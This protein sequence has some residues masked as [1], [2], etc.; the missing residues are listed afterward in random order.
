[1]DCSPPGSSVQGI[2][3]ARILE[4]AVIPFSR[5]SFF[6]PVIKPGSPA[7][8]ADSLPFEPPR[9]APQ[10]KESA[11]KAIRVTVTF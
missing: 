2:L 6:D 3:Q 11:P 9:E 8:Q 4:R 10:Q 1:M 7:V 5:D